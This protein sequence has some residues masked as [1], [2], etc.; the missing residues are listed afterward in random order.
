MFALP[1]WKLG[2][3]LGGSHPQGHFRCSPCT[4]RSVKV[5]MSH[6]SFFCGETACVATA[7]FS[8]SRLFASC[9]D[10]GRLEDDLRMPRSDKASLS[11]SSVFPPPVQSFV[12]QGLT[13]AVSIQELVTSAGTS[14]DGRSHS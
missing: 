2:F 3:P 4:D 5:G 1:L 11:V 10:A 7:E 9:V 12:F 14:L 13:L 6:H 8:P